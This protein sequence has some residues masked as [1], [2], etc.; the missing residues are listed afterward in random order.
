MKSVRKRLKIFQVNFV[1]AKKGSGIK[2]TLMNNCISIENDTNPLVL[3][4]AEEESTID[5]D[6]Q[7]QHSDGD[8][9]AQSSNYEQPSSYEQSSS[10][11]RRKEKL[12]DG[13]AR[14]R[15]S[16]VHCKIQT[17]GYPSRDPDPGCVHCGL[18]NALILW[19][20]HL[21]LH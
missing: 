6:T 4:Q 10:Y 16:L 18:T 17:Y 20:L 8:G 14:L 21:P 19:T 1:Q 12:A 3:H 11:E 15:D 7:Y 5:Y 2:T 9:L 13:W